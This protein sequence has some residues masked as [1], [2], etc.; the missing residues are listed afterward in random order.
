[1]FENFEGCSLT[2]VFC[3]F[4]LTTPEYIITL[5]SEMVEDLSASQPEKEGVR[6]LFVREV[7]GKRT[8]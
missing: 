3:Q 7:E 5:P 2:V 4:Y 8:G 6:P 1:M